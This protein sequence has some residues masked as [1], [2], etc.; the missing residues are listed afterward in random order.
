MSTYRYYGF[1]MRSNNASLSAW[2]IRE[3]TNLLALVGLSLVEQRAVSVVQPAY[4]YLGHT[5]VLGKY[6]HK[7]LSCNKKTVIIDQGA[8]IMCSF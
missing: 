1:P 5:C 3:E 8:Q 4:V 2:L 7:K 6:R